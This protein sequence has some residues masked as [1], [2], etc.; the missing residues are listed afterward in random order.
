M[1]HFPTVQDAVK[2]L[3]EQGFE[4]SLTVAQQKVESNIKAVSSGAKVIQFKR[5]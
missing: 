4:V 2:F 5:N 1:S 3:N